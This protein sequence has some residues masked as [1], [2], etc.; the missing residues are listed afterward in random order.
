[1]TVHYSTRIHTREASTTDLASSTSQASPTTESLG[2]STT[3]TPA[4]PPP[5]PAVAGMSELNNNYNN[6]A[7]ALD[8]GTM[9][10]RVCLFGQYRRIRTHLSKVLA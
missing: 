5:M 7:Q 2:E 1:M 8:L 10:G 3:F 4:K 6:G 9:F